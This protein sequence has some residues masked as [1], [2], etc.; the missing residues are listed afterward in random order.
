MD[1]FKI[2]L[3]SS[4]SLNF[5]KKEFKFKI[6]LITFLL[7]YYRIP[8]FLNNYNCYNATYTH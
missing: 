1:R 6:Y 5:K 2:F 3:T 7:D 4:P 8:E